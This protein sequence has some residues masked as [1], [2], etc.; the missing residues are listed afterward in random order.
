MFG[1]PDIITYSLVR[2]EGGFGLNCN[3]TKSLHTKLQ[4]GQIQLK[5][6]AVQN[7]WKQKVGIAIYFPKSANFQMQD[8][9]IPK[10]REQQAMLGTNYLN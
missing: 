5:L 3:Y 9:V 10:D 1:A 6:G 7:I 4:A 2:Q 8:D